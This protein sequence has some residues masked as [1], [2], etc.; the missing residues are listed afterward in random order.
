M[1]TIGCVVIFTVAFVWGA[2][3]RQRETRRVFRNLQRTA[4][5]MTVALVV[6]FFIFPDA[7][8][9]H[10]RCGAERAWPRPSPPRCLLAGL[11][12]GVRQFP[13]ACSQ[14]RQAC[15]QTRQCSWWRACRWHSSPQALQTAMQAS[16]SGLV[17]PGS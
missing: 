6:V 13:Q 12:Q 2:P 8:L 16:S 14:R 10:G 11:F 15:S 7:R 1:W 5:G 9:A 4:L 17:T 3:W